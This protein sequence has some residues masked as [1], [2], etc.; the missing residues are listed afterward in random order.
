MSGIRLN[1][2]LGEGCEWYNANWG[3]EGRAGVV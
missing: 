2:V 1:G 3:A